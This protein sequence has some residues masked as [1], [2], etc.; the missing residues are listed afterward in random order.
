MGALER[1]VLL[2]TAGR[3]VIRMLPPLVITKEQIDRVVNV[4]DKCL[5]RME[6]RVLRRQS[7]NN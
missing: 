4:L 2:L 5:E 6:E 3:N 7:F 1:G